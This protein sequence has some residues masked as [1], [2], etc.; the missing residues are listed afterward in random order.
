MHK[1]E[2]LPTPAITRFRYDL[3]L[4]TDSVVCRGEGNDHLSERYRISIHLQQN[5]YHAFVVQ[6]FS[7]PNFGIVR[8]MESAE[9]K[10]MLIFWW[11]TKSFQ[12]QILPLRSL[13]LF[14]SLRKTQCKESRGES[15]HSKWR[16]SLK[17][18]ERHHCKIKS[19][20]LLLFPTLK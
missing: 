12:L 18:N 17:L 2:L 1:H 16:P 13:T 9:F 6:W 8:Q 5:Q 3:G 11:K 10:G 7:R 19:E 20:S 4:R 15:R 14:S